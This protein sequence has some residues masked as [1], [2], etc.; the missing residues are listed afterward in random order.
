MIEKNSTFEYSIRPYRK[1][2]LDAM[3]EICIETSSIPLKNEKDREFLLLMF[4][5]A[6]VELTQDCF[7]AVDKKDSPVGYILC[8]VSTR[9][10]FREF[11]EKIFPLIDKLGF[12]YSVEARGIVFLHKLCAVFAPSHLH[13]DLTGSA[14]RRGI[15]TE[16][17]DTLKAHLRSQGIESVQLTC[18][19]N[20]K[21]AISFYKKNG[22]STV[23][24]AFGSCVM[25]SDTK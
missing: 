8:A 21:T 4:C 23:F 19:S 1:S 24:R 16:L 13:I 14:R 17:V 5:D 18:G 12:K 15:G 2:D 10:F 9:E 22:F 25:R 6:Y 20:N 7:V 11:R 3:R